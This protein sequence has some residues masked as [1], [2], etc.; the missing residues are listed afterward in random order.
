MSDTIHEQLSAYLDGE[1]SDEELLLFQ[2]RLTVDAQ[3]RQ[4]LER[5]QLIRE[6]MQHQLPQ[7]LQMSFSDRVL[8]SIQNE[9]DYHESAGG[10]RMHDWFRSLAG[11]G[12]AATVAFVS[13]LT[14]QRA[15]LVA[16]DPVLVNPTAEARMINQFHKSNGM[17]WHVKKPEIGSKLNSY[18]VNHSEYTS[19]NL[20]GM[21]RYSRIA[22]Y[23]M[24]PRMKNKKNK[25]SDAGNREARKA[26]ARKDVK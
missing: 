2:K 4:K 18:L 13:I 5:Y 1:L 19:E 22:G 16:D 11:L 15:T 17:R 9:P 8:D 10:N 25:R 7:S 23:D 20:Q 21:L 12:I 14:I 24:D 3:L 6:G 26:E